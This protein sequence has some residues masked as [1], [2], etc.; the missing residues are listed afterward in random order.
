MKMPFIGGA[1]LGRSK[2]INS[3]Q[4]INLFPVVDNL[5]SKAV[6]ALYGSPGLK[7]YGDS[8]TDKEVRGV[9]EFNDELYAVIG[10]TFYKVTG[11]GGTFTSKGTLNSSSG[12]IWVVSNKTQ[13]MVVDGADGYV[14]DGTTFTEI[15][16]TNFPGA[17]SLS[18]LRE[19]FI[20]TVPDTDE[21]YIS[22]AE[23]ATN[24]TLWVNDF[25]V[26]AAYPDNIIGSIA[27]HDEVIFAGEKSIEFFYYNAGQ[28]ALSET[29]FTVIPGSLIEKGCAAGKSLAKMDNSVFWLSNE[30]Q[31]LRAD[32]YQPRIISSPHIDYQ[33][34]TYET[35]SDAFA[36]TFVQEGHTFYEITFPS[37]NVTWVYDAATDLWHQRLS[38]PHNGR[39]RVN[40]HTLFGNKHIVGDYSNGKLYEQD[41]DTYAED[42]EELR[43]VRTSQVVHNNRNRIF[44]NRFEVEFEAGT[45]LANGQGS[46]PQ[47]MIDWS[48]DGGKTFSNE[49]QR[50]IGKVG[51]YRDRVIVWR[52]GKSR[53]R[54]YR[55]AI[56]DP[57]K[58]VVIDA[59][60]EGKP[61]KF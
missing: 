38:Y 29:P 37:E 53:N 6:L 10:N 55:V 20:V 34:S 41:M 12:Q 33:I 54:I 32:G 50:S 21:F 25:G 27:D 1:Y 51:D 48:D 7:E 45:G 40:C 30:L 13:I 9:H 23:D 61:G 3:Q 57:I 46:D 39:H 44:F 47:A 28:V 60:I 52:M 14:Y 26:A 8:A 42:G 11:N 58:V 49:K 15:A 31:I 5:E 16:D 35:V 19:H 2:N 43:R 18:I 17:S 56:S 24:W 4:C 22:A 36:I 59:Q